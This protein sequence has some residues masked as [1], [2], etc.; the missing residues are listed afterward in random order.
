MDPCCGSGHFLIVAFEMLRRMRMEAE[1]LTPAQAGDA[2]VRDNLFGLEIDAR[3]TQIAAFA[4]ALQAWKA[5]GYRELPIPNIAC[6]GITAK[7]RLEDW[8]KLAKGDELLERSLERLH[9]LFGDAGDL[10]SLIDPLQETSS[11]LMVAQFDEVAP[12]LEEALSREVASDPSGAVF[13]TAVIGA[14]RAVR[15]LARHYTLVTTNPPF[16]GRG[17]QDDQLMRH[18]S[19]SQW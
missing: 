2:V 8:K 18:C 3:C 5:G 4:L 10:G 14:L 11:E 19:Q 7:G 15:L 16:L 1:G 17:K 6:S 13:G 12:L 9:A